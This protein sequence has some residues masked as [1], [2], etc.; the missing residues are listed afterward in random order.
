MK[1]KFFF[2]PHYFSSFYTKNL[3]EDLK[4]PEI[5]YE[6]LEEGGEIYIYIYIGLFK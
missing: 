3:L 6:K 1:R 2:F 4:N 5:K